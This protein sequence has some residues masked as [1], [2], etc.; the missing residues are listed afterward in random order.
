VALSPGARLRPYEVIA[1]LG[2]GGM[3]T[4]PIAADG[5]IYVTGPNPVFALDPRTGHEI[6]EVVLP[7]HAPHDVRD[8]DANEPNVLVN[9][10]SRGQERKLLLHAD[11]NGFFYVFDRKG[12]SAREPYRARKEIQ[13]AKQTGRP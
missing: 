12:A 6:L 2:A 4:V 13:H 7:L 5:V 9:T 11:R 1:R 10:A 3:E 8:W